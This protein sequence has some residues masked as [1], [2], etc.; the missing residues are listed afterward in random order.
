MSRQGLTRKQLELLAYLEARDTTPSYDE[1]RRALNLKSKS[2]IH[3]LIAGLERRGRITRIPACARSIQVVPDAAELRAIPTSR[4]L[5][6]LV[7][8]GVVIEVR[9]AA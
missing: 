4:L 7:A 6:E 2:G 5:S 8:R 3:R 1:M 9:E